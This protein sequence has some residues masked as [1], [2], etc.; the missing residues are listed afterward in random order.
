MKIFKKSENLPKIWKSSE[1][2]KIFLKICLIKCLEGHKSLGSLCNVVKALIVNGARRTKGQGHL[3]SCFGKLKRHCCKIVNLWICF[4]ILW[5]NFI[6]SSSFWS[7]VKNPTQA[8]KKIASAAGDK[9]PLVDDSWLVLWVCGQ[10]AR[11]LGKITN[12]K[13][14]KN[15]ETFHF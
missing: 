8:F 1:N 4:G 6:Q 9:Y 5:V 12:L 13:R 14:K 3:L 15:Y 10:F 11:F 7:P 2:L